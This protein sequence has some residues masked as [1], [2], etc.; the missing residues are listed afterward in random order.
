MHCLRVWGTVEL[1]GRAPGPS[2]KQ[3]EGT[4]TAVSAGCSG[5]RGCHPSPGL[6][7]G[8]PPGSGG[9]GWGSPRSLG[10]PAPLDSAAIPALGPRRAPLSSGASDPWAVGAQAPHAVLVVAPAQ[11]RAAACE[12]GA[13]VL[14]ASPPLCSQ[15]LCVL[16][17]VP[18]APLA[19]CSSRMWS[20]APPTGAWG[21]SEEG[22]VGTVSRSWSVDRTRPGPPSFP[23]TGRL[24]RGTQP[25][26]GSPGP[27]L[28][29]SGRQLRA[30]PHLSP[31]VTLDELTKSHAGSSCKAPKPRC[32]GE[33]ATSAGPTPPGHREAGK[34][35][36]PPQ[37]VFGQRA[38][39]TSAALV[40]HTA[41]GR[42][43]SGDPPADSPAFPS[44]GRGPIKC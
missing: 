19:R 6:A 21:R 15:S 38:G 20:K 14:S 9:G 31:H 41:G 29:A 43:G 25:T 39:K 3:V 33:R 22:L 24:R 26:P 40:T 8:H 23:P 35:S 1:P 4:G 13:H 32:K 18:P 36:A 7:L 17:Q 10:H 27:E 16:T 5:R 11:T 42:A 2:S 44:E 34:L 37:A 30:Q 28:V 12:L